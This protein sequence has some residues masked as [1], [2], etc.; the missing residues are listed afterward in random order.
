MGMDFIPKLVGQSEF[1]LIKKDQTVDGINDILHQTA[2]KLSRNHKASIM[3]EIKRQEQA[4][5]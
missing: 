5:L 2:T 3:R 1:E 4:E